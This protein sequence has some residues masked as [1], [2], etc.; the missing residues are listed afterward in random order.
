MSTPKKT[1][2]KT[3]AKIPAFTVK[4]IATIRSLRRQ[5]KTLKDIGKAL[6]RSD[7]TIAAFVKQD[8]ECCT[9]S[10]KAKCKTPCKEQKCY[11]KA[12]E[13]PATPELKKVFVKKVF[14]V[15]TA[16]KPT[17]KPVAKEE[18][19]PKK[20]VPGFDCVK[21]PITD[22]QRKALAVG[23]KLLELADGIHELLAKTF[24]S[25]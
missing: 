19:A 23:F 7:K 9:A 18:K 6:H 14:L 20:G 24:N 5:G 16:K 10:D 21:V 1:A 8:N 17:A 25:L 3:A 4:E 12:K 15:P 2:K 11:D 22:D 13:T